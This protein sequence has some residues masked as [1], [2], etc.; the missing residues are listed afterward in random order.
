[1]Y[2]PIYL[3]ICVCRKYFVKYNYIYLYIKILEQ[4]NE[5][6]NLVLI[7]FDL[8]LSP[9]LGQWSTKL[10]TPSPVPTPSPSKTLKSA[11]IMLEI[12]S[13][14]IGLA[15]AFLQNLHIT[16]IASSFLATLTL[17]FVYVQTPSLC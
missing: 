14:K 10:Q 16:V 15:H 5:C 4:F 1:M 8:F 9:T 11:R 17:T 3:H 7:W 12:F 6:R 2:T 13:M